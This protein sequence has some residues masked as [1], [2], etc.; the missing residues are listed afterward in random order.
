MD[1]TKTCRLSEQEER[2]E[3]YESELASARED[4]IDVMEGDGW[5]IKLVD[6]KELEK[7]IVGKTEKPVVVMFRSGL[8][9]IYNGS[10]VF[11]V[12][13]KIISLS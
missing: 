6:S 10:L 12:I 13:Q 1:F 9:V 4:L 2:C 7:F 11:N 5:V 8:P 3:E